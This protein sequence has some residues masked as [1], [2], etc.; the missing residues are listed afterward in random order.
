MRLAEWGLDARLRALSGPPPC[1]PKIAVE[2]VWALVCGL[3]PEKAK[4]HSLMV[5]QVALDESAEPPFFVM[6]GYIATVETWAA[7]TKD[8]CAELAS[9]PTVR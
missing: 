7:F 1:D 4:R 8:W 2:A 3:P 9:P 5:I 6:G